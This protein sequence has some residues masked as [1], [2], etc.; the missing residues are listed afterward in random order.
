MKQKGCFIDISAVLVLHRMARSALIVPVIKIFKKRLTVGMVTRA[1][2]Q[3]DHVQE[4]FHNTS[5]SKQK[6]VHTSSEKVV[7]NQYSCR[8][9]YSQSIVDLNIFKQ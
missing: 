2:S 5:K 4:D 9:V 6:F 3:P 7:N 1:Q 8:C